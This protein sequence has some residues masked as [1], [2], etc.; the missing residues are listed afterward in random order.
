MTSQIS[1]VDAPAQPLETTLPPANQSADFRPH[2]ELAERF[3]IHSVDIGRKSFR[4]GDTVISIDRS[5][6]NSSLKITLAPGDGFMCDHT[7]EKGQC[8]DGIRINSGLWNW[9][10]PARVISRKLAGEKVMLR[11]YWNRSQEPRT[12]TL[13][14]SGTSIVALNPE[15][16][17]GSITARKGSFVGAM[18]GNGR[19][20]VNPGFEIDFGLNILAGDDAIKQKLKG[21][22]HVILE[23]DGAL[24]ISEVTRASNFE[25]DGYLAYSNGLT[26]GF[27]FK[28]HDVFAGLFHKERLRQVRMRRKML[29]GQEGGY[30]ITSVPD[31]VL[32]AGARHQQREGARNGAHPA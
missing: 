15:K 30:V 23:T 26:S 9:L 24:G 29:G 18:V 5:A 21:T 31:R 1:V 32:H 19:N 13:K 12:I 28:L 10:N 3:G 6:T 17:G 16:A 4:D 25:P 8:D 7:I 22:G 11:T 2:F 20:P 14:A 27:G